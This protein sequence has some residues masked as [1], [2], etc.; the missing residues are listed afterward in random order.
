MEQDSFLMSYD[1]VL[2]IPLNYTSFDPY[3]YAVLDSFSVYLIIGCM[4]DC[5]IGPF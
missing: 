2:D 4:L 3:P 5:N 1:A